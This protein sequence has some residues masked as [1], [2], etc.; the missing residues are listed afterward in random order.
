MTQFKKGREKQGGR[1]KGTPNKATADIKAMLLESFTQVGGVEYLTEQAIVNPVAYMGL[2]KGVIP[3][4]QQI[5]VNHHIK[6]LRINMMGIDGI[7]N[8]IEP[9]EIEGTVIDA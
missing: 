2:L 9:K 6:T 3:K 5:E 1:K 8:K 4:E 7:A